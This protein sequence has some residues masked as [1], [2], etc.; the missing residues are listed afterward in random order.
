[1]FDAMREIFENCLSLVAL[2]PN[3]IIPDFFPGT[4]DSLEHSPVFLHSKSISDN[5]ESMIDVT[6]KQNH[7]L[8]R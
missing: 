8:F 1:M 2:L 6:D 3:A 7:P 5:F 4:Q